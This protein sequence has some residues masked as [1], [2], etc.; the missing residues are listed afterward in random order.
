MMVSDHS[1]NVLY[2]GYSLKVVHATPQWLVFIASKLRDKPELSPERQMVR[3][4]NEEEVLKRAKVRVDDLI[5]R[6][7]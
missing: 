4:W 5:E 3:G 1:G 7:G 6:Q 2:R